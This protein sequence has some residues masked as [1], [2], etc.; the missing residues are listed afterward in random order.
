MGPSICRP[1]PL[2]DTAPEY[3]VHM[4]FIIRYAV[5]IFNSGLSGMLEYWVKVPTSLMFSVQVFT[6]PIMTAGSI[7]VPFKL[8]FVIYPG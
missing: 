6:T 4:L 3:V 7:Y 1:L 5:M 8:R 2:K